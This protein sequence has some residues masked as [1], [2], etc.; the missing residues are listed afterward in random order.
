VLKYIVQEN[1][2]AM[3]VGRSHSTV[4]A[5]QCNTKIVSICAT[6]SKHILEFITRILTTF[7]AELA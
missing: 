1:N 7:A 6:V 4:D 3:T 2:A 5:C